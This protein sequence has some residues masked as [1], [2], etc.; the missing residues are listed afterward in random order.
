[1]NILIVSDQRDWILGEI[2]EKWVEHSKPNHKLCH[3]AADAPNFAT[4]LTRAQI[5][6]QLVHFLSPW[7]FRRYYPSVWRPCST[8]IWHAVSWDNFDDVQ[9]MWDAVATGSLSWLHEIESRYGTEKVAG[10]LPF[11]VDTVRFSPILNGRSRFLDKLN[12]P[13]ET[14]IIGFAGKK[15]SNE[16]DRKGLTQLFET[17]RALRDTIPAPVLLRIAGKQWGIEDIPKDLSHNVRIEEFLSPAEF[18]KF[19]SEID[20]YLCQSSVEGV[21]Y[22]VLEAMS[23]G[24]VVLSTPVGVVPEVILPWENGVIING[25][26]IVVNTIEA[27]RRIIDNPEIAAK[28]RLSARQRIIEKYDW[29]TLKI[30]DALHRLYLVALQHHQV[31]SRTHLALRFLRSMGSGMVSLY[32]Q[33]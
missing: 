19:Y 28:M 31:R 26:D 7:T 33:L 9:A 12:L 5:Q 6:T 17:I 11:G 23:C 13:P 8:T 29:D 18:P 14:I 22:P 24:A 21:P 20:I 2:A 27:V 32:K 25:P 30:S 16:R 10:I 3:L 1:M 15:S 4:T